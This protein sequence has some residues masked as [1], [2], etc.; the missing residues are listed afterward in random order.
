M[1]PEHQFGADARTN[2]SP[3][4]LSAE[5]I[6]RP[7]VRPLSLNAFQAPYPPC[8]DSTN[9]RSVRT[10]SSARKADRR[11]SMRVWLAAWR[12]YQLEVEAMTE[13]KQVAK[14]VGMVL[15][16][17][18]LLTEL[19][20]Q[21]E[22]RWRLLAV[23]PTHRLEFDEIPWPIFSSPQCPYELNRQIT[24]QNVATFI[25]SEFRMDI[26]DKTTARGRAR[27]ELMKWHP[28]KF[29]PR[30]I[31]AVSDEHRTVVVKAVRKVA[32]ILVDICNAEDATRDIPELV[33]MARRKL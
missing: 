2:G 32:Q 1:D 4:P 13:E 30:L 19:A 26:R 31:A 9:R 20:S 15:V 6:R 16:L 18:S 25:L 17:R 27:A 33:A 10:C 11:E 3:P 28:D 24:H 12:K 8:A 23:D 7:V 29:E 22:E 14:K 21:Y 5:N